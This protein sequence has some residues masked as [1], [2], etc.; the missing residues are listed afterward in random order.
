MNPSIEIVTLSRGR[1]KNMEMMQALVPDITVVVDKAEEADYLR[2]VDRERLVTHPGKRG[3][4]AVRNWILKNIGADIVVMLDDDLKGVRCNVGSM[5]YITNPDE[6]RDI[7]YNAAQN[8]L[9]V[10]VN[11]FGFSRTENVMWLKAEVEPIKPMH[12][13]YGCVGVIGNAKRIEYDEGLPSRADLDWTMSVLLRERV[14]YADV[15][16]TFDFGA[17]FTG[18]GGNSG[19]VSGDD[20]RESMIAVKRRWGKAI[21]VGGVGMGGDRTTS[22]GSIRVSRKNRTAQR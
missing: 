12:P 3:A 18:S 10:G 6:I 22:A 11:V 15:R 8:C 17:S 7:I 16:F 20:F 21:K 14:V 13:I 1:P 19:L 5:R 9:D 4:P 2:Y